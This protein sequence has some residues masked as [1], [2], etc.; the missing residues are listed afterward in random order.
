MHLQLRVRSVTIQRAGVPTDLNL[1][2]TVAN[3]IVL[4]ALCHVKYIEKLGAF[5]SVAVSSKGHTGEIG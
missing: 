5:F 2:F 3:I 4:L 1:R